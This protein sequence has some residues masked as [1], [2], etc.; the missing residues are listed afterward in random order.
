MVDAAHV[1]TGSIHSGLQIGH[2]LNCCCILANLK[3]AALL[4]QDLQGAS[5]AYSA[6]LALAE[7][8]TADKLAAASNRAACRLAQRNYSSTVHD[9]N[10]ALGLLTGQELHANS[11]VHAWLASEKGALLL[12]FRL[13]HQLPT[14]LH[15]VHTD[16]HLS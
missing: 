1:S 8:T 4:A 3:N 6:V 14:L 5:D 2:S 13:Q 12:C 7:G 11:G 15:L 9:C 10:L 16:I